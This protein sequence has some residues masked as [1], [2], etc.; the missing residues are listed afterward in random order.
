MRTG[1]VILTPYNTI[2]IVTK[3]TDDYVNWVSFDSDNCS[4]G[5]SLKDT[6]REAN[7]LL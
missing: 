6:K 2:V 5:G 4:G 7:L 3:V 1:N